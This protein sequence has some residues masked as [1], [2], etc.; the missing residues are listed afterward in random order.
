[1]RTAFVVAWIAVGVVIVLNPARIGAACDQSSYQSDCYVLRSRYHTRPWDCSQDC[2]KENE[3]DVKA[4]HIKF[5]E[6]AAREKH[7]SQVSNRCFIRS[8]MDL[9]TCMQG[10]EDRLEICHMCCMSLLY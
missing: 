2:T 9:R 3:D 8:S 6:D 4:C 5:S 10:A 7:A 1:M